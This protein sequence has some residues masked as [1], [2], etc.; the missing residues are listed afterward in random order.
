MGLIEVIVAAFILAVGLTALAGLSVHFSRQTRMAWERT[1]TAVARQNLQERMWAMPFGNVTSGSDVVE[2]H[3]AVWT[4]TDESPQVKLIRVADQIIP[5]CDREDTDKGKES[6]DKCNKGKQEPNADLAPDSI[7][8][9]WGFQ[10]DT[11][12]IRRMKR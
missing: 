3:I 6:K 9:Q 1:E 5:P 4:V 11:F 8:G 2:T 10:S 12:T 7:Q